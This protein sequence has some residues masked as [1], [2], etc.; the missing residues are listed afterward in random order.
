MLRM[1]VRPGRNIDL[2]HRGG[3]A[4]PA[5]QGAGPP[6]GARV[7]GA[8]EP[9]HRRGAAATSQRRGRVRRRMRVSRCSIV[10][11]TGM[12]GA[13]KTTALRALEDLGLLLRRQPAAAAA[14]AVRRAAS[15]TTGRD[16]QGG[17]GGRRPRGRVPAPAA[18]TTLARAARRTGHPLEVLFLDAA[19]DV[20]LRRFSETRRRHP[21]VGRRPARPASPTS[22]RLLRELREAPRRSSTPAT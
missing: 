22:A 7:P 20:L 9:R 1:P 12:S 2:D 19:D 13:G 4:Q 11:V 18:A 6:L 8:A 17:A 14:R 16:R 15:R 3:G 10:V 21:L 5:A